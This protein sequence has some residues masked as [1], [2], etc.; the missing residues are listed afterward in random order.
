MFNKIVIGLCVIYLV[1]FAVNLLF[2]A[3]IS[4]FPQ[5]LAGVAFGIATAKIL[6]LI[7]DKKKQV[8]KNV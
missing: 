2:G 6:D 4:D 7:P 1:L 5:W 8:L 3:G